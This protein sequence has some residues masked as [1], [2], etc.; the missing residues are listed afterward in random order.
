MSDDAM[1][2]SVLHD[3]ST[4]NEDHHVFVTMTIANQ[5]FGIPV[6]LVQD[7]LGPQHINIIPLAP[8]EV[9]GSL[10]LRGRVVTAIDVRKRLGLPPRAD[11]DPGMSVVVEH[12]NELYSLIIDEVGEVLSLP[13]SA[14][15]GIPATLDDLWRSIT[16]GIY[17]LDDQ[18]MVELDIDRVLDFA[19]AA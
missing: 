15:E 12:G 13:A 7:V 14:S 9:A 18:L 3:D 10:N 8:P 2:P 4:N 6:L 5:L 17:Q 19:E 16:N 11:D 1:I